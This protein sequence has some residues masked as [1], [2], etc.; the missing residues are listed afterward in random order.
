[1]T[2][3]E[4]IRAGGPIAV[5]HP[6]VMHDLVTQEARTLVAEKR[7]VAELQSRRALQGQGQTLN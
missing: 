1:M 4:Q 7:K 6:N 2:C 5:T 3:Y